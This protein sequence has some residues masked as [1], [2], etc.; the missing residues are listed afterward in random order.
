[1]IRVSLLLC[2]AALIG[3]GDKPPAVA[4]TT[5]A[6]PPEAVSDLVFT[7]PKPVPGGVVLRL[8]PKSNTATESSLVGVIDVWSVPGKIS[9]PKDAVGRSK[10]SMD[11]KTR[12]AAA[13]ATAV[14]LGFESGTLQMEGKAKGEWEMLGGQRGEV[15]FD[16]RGALLADQSN[17]FEGLFGAGM[18]IF[19]ESPV[20]PGSTWSSENTRDM[21]PFGPVKLKE[22]FTYKGKEKKDGLDLHRIDST[23]SGSLE[24]MSITATYYIREDGLPHSSSI[25]SKASTPIATNDDGSQMWAGFTVNVEIRPKK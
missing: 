6:P 25:R 13:D 24:G 7:E 12:V 1:M 11:F 10:I 4:P 20:G 2:L 8:N 16:R 18:L 3:C 15:R 14:T 5:S 19:P 17:L 22:Q 23:A 9:V 21:P